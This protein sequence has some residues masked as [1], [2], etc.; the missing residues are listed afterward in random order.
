MLHGNKSSNGWRLLEQLFG[1]VVFSVYGP[2]YQGFMSDD[3]KYKKNICVICGHL[4][5]KENEEQNELERNRVSSSL[6]KKVIPAVEALF[7]G[8]KPAVATEKEDVKA[9][10][11]A[12]EKSFV[13]LKGGFFALEEAVK[14]G[15]K[16]PS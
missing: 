14:A 13:D 9:A 16:T 11:L 12:I 3:H 8:L 7:E 1:S 2:T 5:N 6:A 10:I 4:K 15:I